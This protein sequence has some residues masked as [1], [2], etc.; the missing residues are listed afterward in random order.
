[1]NKKLKLEELKRISVEE[2]QKSKKQ[3]IVVVLD[4][5]RSAFNI[6]S[7]FRTADALA[8]ERLV[9]CGITA[10]PPHR[11]IYKTA[12]GASESVCWT[13]SE[14]T[15]NAID[16][17]KSE[18]FVILSL[19][20]VS[21]STSLNDF[22]PESSAKYALVIGNEVEGVDQAVIDASNFC[23]EIPQFGTKHSLNVSVSTGIALWDIINK[24]KRA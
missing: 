18:G 24:I 21:N 8:I 4:N 13:Y 1:M 10:R 16:G 17:L 20:Q 9:L 2:F 3:P 19:E 11:E 23:I 7:V 14:S 15:M 12:L 5:I 6:G 22:I